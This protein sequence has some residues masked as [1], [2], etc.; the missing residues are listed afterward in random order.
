MNMSFIIWE[1]KYCAFD[2]YD[3]TYYGYYIIKCISYACTL[4]LDLGICGQVISFGEM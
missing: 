3:S 4:Q 1:V 2:N